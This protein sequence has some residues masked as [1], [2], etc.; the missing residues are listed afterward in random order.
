MA[1]VALLSELD[2]SGPQN[3][4]FNVDELA[5]FADDTAA[6]IVTVSSVQRC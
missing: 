4:S 5:V 6:S 1:A 2:N 3:M